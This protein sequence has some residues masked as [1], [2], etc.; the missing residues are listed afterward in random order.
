MFLSD[1]LNE[2]GTFGPAM[3]DAHFAAYKK[4]CAENDKNTK[5]VAQD[6][7]YEF[8][9]PIRRGTEVEFH[10]DGSLKRYKF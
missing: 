7:N 4:I 1:I 6:Q 5:P 3:D 9:F 10:K 8:E 2:D